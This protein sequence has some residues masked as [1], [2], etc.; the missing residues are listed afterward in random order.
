MQ[1][2]CFVSTSLS[3]LAVL[4]SMGVGGHHRCPYHDDHT[5]S[6]S[7]WQDGEK[8]H[9]KCHAGCGG[10]TVTDAGAGMSWV[11][12]VKSQ[13]AQPTD[14]LEEYAIEKHFNLMNS[15]SDLALLAAKRNVSKDVAIM[16]AIGVSRSHGNTYWTI[17]VYGV[18]GSILGVKC[19]IEGHRYGLKCWWYK[20][21]NRTKH[22]VSALYPVE[23]N[24]ANKDVYICGG[25]LKAL[26]MISL[27]YTA[28][29][30]T[31]GES[32]AW[33]VGDIVPLLG[34][35]VTVIHDRDDAGVKFAANIA[36][37]FLRFGKAVSLI[38][39]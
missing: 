21:A 35:N 32:F 37:K 11:Q 34:K 9:W 28:V 7:I 18:N 13:P 30:P 24:I 25:E 20:A 38:S 26:R 4:K 33:K 1:K 22:G 29:S 23:R 3:D 19:H 12:R 14:E 27:G 31:S 6:L 15:P 16:Y 10:A 36:A 5:G 17:P 39:V 8:W 2:E